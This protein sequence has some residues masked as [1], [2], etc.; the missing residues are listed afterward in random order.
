MGPEEEFTVCTFNSLTLFIG[1][2]AGDIGDDGDDA[3]APVHTRQNKHFIT[4][5]LNWITADRNPFLSL[6]MFQCLP[7]KDQTFVYKPPTQENWQ[8]LPMP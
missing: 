5:T 3:L 8:H 2:D 6:G 7:P 4:S 1:G